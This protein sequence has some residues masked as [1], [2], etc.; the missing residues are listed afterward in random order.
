MLLLLLIAIF[1]RETQ[2]FASLQV[3]A[4][5]FELY[6]CIDDRLTPS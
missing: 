6:H 4:I 5:I 3:D 1:A 2:N